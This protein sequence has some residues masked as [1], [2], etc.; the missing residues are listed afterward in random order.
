VVFVSFVAKIDD[1]AHAAIGRLPCLTPDVFG[2]RDG[3]PREWHWQ[4]ITTRSGH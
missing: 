4:S 2:S 3:T 1:E